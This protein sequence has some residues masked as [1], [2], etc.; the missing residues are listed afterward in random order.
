MSC[1]ASCVLDENFNSSVVQSADSGA[2]IGGRVGLSWS[3]RP[4]CTPSGTSAH[5]HAKK[6]LLGPQ[7]AYSAPRSSKTEDMW[8]NENERPGGLVGLRTAVIGCGAADGCDRLWDWQGGW[9]GAGSMARHGMAPRLMTSKAD[10]HRPL[11]PRH[12]PSN[13]SPL[14]FKGPLCPLKSFSVPLLRP[15]APSF[16]RRLPCRVSAPRCY[17][18][19]M[20]L[21]VENYSNSPSS[22]VP[23]FFA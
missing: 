17:Q 10:H 14:I 3:P 12:S 9:E 18:S 21:F 1:F 7:R 11:P 22:H 15:F 16:R 6:G 19:A 4:W 2:P 5:C 13:P 23:P 8:R 20:K